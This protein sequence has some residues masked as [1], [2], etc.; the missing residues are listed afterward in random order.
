MQIGPTGELDYNIP[1][2]QTIKPIC[3]IKNAQ[4]RYEAGVCW[5]DEEGNKHNYE[6]LIGCGDITTAML[7]VYFNLG[8][9]QVAYNFMPLEDYQAQ[10]PNVGIT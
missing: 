9:I 7:D 4:G 10:N 1:L 5:C 6:T 3:F 2:F 8:G